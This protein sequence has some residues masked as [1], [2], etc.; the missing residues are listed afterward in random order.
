VSRACPEPVT[1]RVNLW[2]M[3]LMPTADHEFLTVAE[4]AR[5]LQCSEPT[6]RRRIRDGELPAVKLGRGRSVL[7]VPRAALEAWLYGDEGDA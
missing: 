7:R 6:V 3:T 1:A 5:L 4:V 2:G